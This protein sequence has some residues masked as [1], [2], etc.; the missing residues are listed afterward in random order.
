MDKGLIVD[1]ETTG[2][3]PEKDKIIEIGIIEFG[4]RE[5]FTPHL[6]SSYSELQDPKVLLDKKI[7]EISHIDDFMLKEKNIDWQKVSQLFAT[8]SIVIAHNVDFDRSFLLKIKQIKE[9]NIHWG[10]SQ[11]HIDWNKHGYQTSALNYLAADHGFVNPFAHRAL[12]D[13]ATTFR[14]ISPY[15]KE[16]IDRSFQKETKI[17]AYSAPFKAKDKLKEQG[18]RWDSKER[19]W[20]KV[21]FENN[22]EQESKFLSENIYNGKSL[23][24]EYN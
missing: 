1:L 2:L 21:V 22:L 15:L 9:L 18:Y 7:K 24:K 5:D 10:C 8:S 4:I 17:L 13:C 20:N 19:V 11:K 16:L 3:D 12:F 14:L 23:H 6:L